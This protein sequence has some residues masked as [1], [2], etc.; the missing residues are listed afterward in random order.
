MLKTAMRG[1]VEG[2]ALAL[3]SLKDFC[4]VRRLGKLEPKISNK[5]RNCLMRSHHLYGTLSQ[6][7]GSA[8][9][10]LWAMDTFDPPRT[11]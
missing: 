9:F 1:F 6:L 11:S 2:I 5:D 8:H 10:R 4:R 7:M 3:P